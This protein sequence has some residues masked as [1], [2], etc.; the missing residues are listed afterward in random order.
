MP[1]SSAEVR[2]KIAPLGHGIPGV[3]FH[4]RSSDPQSFF[5]FGE[6]PHGELSVVE[7]SVQPVLP[8]II[9]T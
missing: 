7:K 4:S 5:G 2:H 8:L 9:A 3:L 1:M 6:T